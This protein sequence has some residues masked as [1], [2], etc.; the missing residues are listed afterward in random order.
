VDVGRGRQAD[1]THLRP[2]PLQQSLRIRQLRAGL[3]EAEADPARKDRDREHRI[4]RALGGREA[5][6]QRVVVV[7]HELERTRPAPPHP[8]ERIVRRGGNLRREFFDEPGQLR[9]RCF[10]THLIPPPPVSQTV[11]ETGSETV[12]DPVSD[13]VSQTV[14]DP[15]S[16]TVCDTVCDTSPRT[17]ENARMTRCRDAG[18]VLR[19][20]SGQVSRAGRAA[21][22]AVVAALASLTLVAQSPSPLN[23]ELERIFAREEYTPQTFTQPAWIDGGARYA[24]VEPSTSAPGTKDAK[25]IVE[26][27][28]APGTRTVLVAATSLKPAGAAAPL[29]IDGYAWSADRTKLLLYTNSKKV[30]RQN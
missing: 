26:Y 25:D 14:C 11:C 30:W 10:Y 18:I 28:T 24:A 3:Q 15:V 8:R 9:R 29:A 4:G 6:R 7:V 16:E 2:R 12:S 23:A 1:V 19:L 5:N 20:R 17:C 13:P 22:P 27:D 21:L